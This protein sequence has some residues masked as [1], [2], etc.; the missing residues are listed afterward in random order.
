MAYYKAKMHQIRFWLGLRP[1]PRWGAYSAPPDPL[2]GFK[3]P[4]SKGRAG[5]RKRKRRGGEREREG[6]EREKGSVPG[7]FSQILAPNVRHYLDPSSKTLVII[8]SRLTAS[9]VLL[10]CLITFKQSFNESML[11]YL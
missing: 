7:S 11:F 5:N 1:R 6:R 3:G 4:N 8:I 2:T 10:L 9:P